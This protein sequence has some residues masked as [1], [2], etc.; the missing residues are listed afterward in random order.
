VVLL[1]EEGRTVMKGMRPA[2]ILLPPPTGPAPEPAGQRQDATKSRRA[3]PAAGGAD[4]LD[5]AA[6]AWKFSVSRRQFFSGILG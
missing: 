1:T 3:T 4:A 5:G 6:Q 2:R